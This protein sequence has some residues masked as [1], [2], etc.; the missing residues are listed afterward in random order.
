MAEG[1]VVVTGNFEEGQVA[2]ALAEA[3]AR[4]QRAV[5]CVSRHRQGVEAAVA[6]LRA[7]APGGWVEGEALDL[8]DPAS[9]A[10]LHRW[11]PQGS[12]QGVLH[13]AGGL[14]Y[15][16]PASEVTLEEFR[17][18][19]EAN[20][21]TTFLI[22][23]W[24][25]GALATG[26]GFVAFSR[27]GSPKAQMLAYNAAKAGLEAVIHTLAL[28][29]RPRQ[30]RFNAV[31]PGLIATKSNIEALSPTSLQG[32]TRLEDVVRVALWLLGAQSAGVNGQV[33][34]VGSG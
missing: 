28:E 18:E 7:L 5:L 23:Q 2:W 15:V 34:A 1:T 8:A 22:G 27:S 19:V 31:A 11:V 25:L 12:V 21:T 20:L 17:R 29:G 13:A 26:G 24:A 32:W 4:T 3:L 30:L 10:R 33:V 9:Y 14:H 6:R 16:K